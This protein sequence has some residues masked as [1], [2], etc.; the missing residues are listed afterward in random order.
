MLFTVLLLVVE[1]CLCGAPEISAAPYSIPADGL[2]RSPRGLLFDLSSLLDSDH[3]VADPAIGELTFSIKGPL[4]M[5]CGAAVNPAN[6]V[7]ACLSVAK[8]GVSDP[9]KT[10]KTAPETETRVVGLAATQLIDDLRE[11]TGLVISYSGGDLCTEKGASVPS[12]TII[13]I[14]CGDRY[15]AAPQSFSSSKGCVR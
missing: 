4:L 15:T 5:Q 3:F 12:K 7:S 6:P 1:G 9:K 11:A 8:Q 13:K 10:S 14:T 2:W